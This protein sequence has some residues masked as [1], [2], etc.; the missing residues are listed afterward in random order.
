MDAECTVAGGG[1]ASHDGRAFTENTE[2]RRLTAA[3][4]TRALDELHAFHCKHDLGQ[5]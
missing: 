5:L 2:R 4:T 1:R 3:A